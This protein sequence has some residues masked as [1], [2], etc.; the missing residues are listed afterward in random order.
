MVE[1]HVASRIGKTGLRDR[2]Q[3][4]EGGSTTIG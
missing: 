3:L 1:K 4:G 2:I